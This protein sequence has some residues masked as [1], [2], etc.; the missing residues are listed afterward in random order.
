MSEHGILLV[1]IT[2]AATPPVAEKAASG[3]HMFEA[4]EQGETRIRGA[5]GEG[6]S[7]IHGFMGSDRSCGQLQTEAR[8]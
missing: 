7:R 8:P 5:A 4:H 2:R 6:A 3:T 1:L